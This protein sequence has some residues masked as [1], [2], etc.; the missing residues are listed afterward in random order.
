MSSA[1]V[2]AA[3]NVGWSA[4][5]KRTDR[6]REAESELKRVNHVYL[7]IALQLEAFAHR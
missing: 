2:S 4:W 3:I 6:R 7:E 1:V 5:N